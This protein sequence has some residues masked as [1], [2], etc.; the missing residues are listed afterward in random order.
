MSKK[1]NR[2]QGPQFIKYFPHIIE[3][4]KILGGSGQPSEVK[5]VIADM[6][7]LSDSEQNE[8][9]PKSGASRYSNQVDW[10][11]FYLAKA[12]YIDSS[13]RGVWILTDRGRRENLSEEEALSVFKNIH[14]QFEIGTTGQVIDETPIAE[15]TAEKGSHRQ[16]LMEML[17]SCSPS[18]FERLCQR[19]LRDSGFEQVFVVGRSGDGG[20]DGH[21]MLRINPFVSF[22]VY[23]QA[24]RYK[25]VVG[26]SVVRDFR[27]AISG[28]ADK[29][30]IITTGTFTVDAKTEA[31]RDGT[32]PI[33]LVSGE[34][35]LTMF[36]SL[37]LGLIP[38]NYYEVDEDFFEAFKD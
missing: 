33:E 25:G 21:G 37:E 35:L 36:E 13:K 16:K 12:G 2:S 7:N 17:L 23:F 9:L 14:Q 19:L 5:D 26:P 30:I 20:I 38:R 15:E 27:G 34:E 10:A 31:N 4:L 6:L 3:A 22:R 8:Q 11:R 24:K 29:G 32:L 18:G 28:R 1:Q